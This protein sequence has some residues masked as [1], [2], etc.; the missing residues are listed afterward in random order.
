MVGGDAGGG[1]ALQLA[2]WQVGHVAVDG[3]ARRQRDLYLAHHLRVAAKHA[4]EV[5]HLGQETD[6][7]AL[8]HPRDDVGRDGGTAGLE[9]AAKVRHA[10]GCAEEEVERRLAPVADHKVDTLHAEH[11][12]YLVGVGHDTD[13]AVAHH[14]TG[15]LAGHEH[16]TLDV[17]VTVDEP[18]QQVWPSRA[19][20]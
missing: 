17:D 8:H 12:A 14:H 15:I 6:V 5:H 2:E 13:G 11:V 3:L 9:V 10:T 4:C 20:F 18:G 16:R 7:G 1:I 19:G